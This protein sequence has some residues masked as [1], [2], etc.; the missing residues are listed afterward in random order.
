MKEV[1]EILKHEIDLTQLIKLGRPKNATIS[2]EWG[3]EFVLTQSLIQI[4]HPIL[5]I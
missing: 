4:Q 5:A 1:D 2:P 3:V